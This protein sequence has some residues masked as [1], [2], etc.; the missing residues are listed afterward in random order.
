MTTTV[1]PALDEA[2][3]LRAYET[4]QRLAELLEM[5]G[6]DERA[7]DLRDLRAF[8]FET[9]RDGVPCR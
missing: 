9:L 6:M 4:A 5:L 8:L 1:A 7:A 2:T 3:L